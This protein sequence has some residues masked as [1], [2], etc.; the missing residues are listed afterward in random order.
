M[1]A[2]DDEPGAVSPFAVETE[3]NG[4][5]WVHEVVHSC[6][7]SDWRLDES[8]R[9][10]ERAHVVERGLVYRT[11]LTSRCSQPPPPCQLRMNAVALAPVTPVAFASGAPSLLSDSC[12]ESFSV[13]VAEL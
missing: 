12:R 8:M 7:L 3:T 5:G 6:T 9:S 11:V 1:H 13:A 10:D 4:I 2:Y